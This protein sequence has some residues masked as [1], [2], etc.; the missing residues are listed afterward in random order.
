[1]ES[2]GNTSGFGQ[3]W[4]GRPFYKGRFTGSYPA[5]LLFHFPPDGSWWLGQIRGGQLGWTLVADTTGTFV[6]E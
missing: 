4:D 6:F 3:V 2:L 1:V 5:E